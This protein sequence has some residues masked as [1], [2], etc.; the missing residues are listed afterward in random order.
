MREEVLKITSHIECEVFGTEFTIRVDTDNKNRNSG[1]VFIQIV[2][3]AP[4]IKT[5]QILEWHGRKWYLSE[6]MTE[7]EIVKTCYAAFEAAVKHEV[8]EGFK[9][10]GIAPFNPH[11]DYK[12]LLAI[13]HMEVQR[14]PINKA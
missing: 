9:I 14:E 8:M 10:G 13:S 2:Y 5:G 11:V 1:R 3:H 12:Q 7:D 4:C 6:H